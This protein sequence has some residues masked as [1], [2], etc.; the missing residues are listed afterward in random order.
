MVSQSIEI[1]V[2]H[3]LRAAAKAGIHCRRAVL[4][5]SQAKGIADEWSDIDLVVIA[6]ELEPPTN[7]QMVD[8]LWE[9]RA[10]TDSRV[11]PIPCGEREWE[12]DQSRPILQIARNEGVEIRT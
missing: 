4:F 5:G 8:K 11:E 6:P 1:A 7:R 9:L 12:T 3:Y 2:Q 10:I